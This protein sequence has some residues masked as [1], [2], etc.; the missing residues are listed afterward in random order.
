MFIV[1]GQKLGA[2]LKSFRPLVSYSVNIVGSIC[3]VGLFAVF[4]DLMLK[5]LY[6]FLFGLLVTLWFFYSSKKQLI[7]QSIIV[8]FT[9][10]LVSQLDPTS[11]WSPYYKIDISPMV[12]KSSHKLFGF[13]IEVNNLYHQKAFDLSDKTI[14][15]LPELKIYKD[16]YEFPYNFIQPAKVLILGAG[17]GND[18][19]AA[20]R[21]GVKE[22]YAVEIDPFIA[23]LGKEWQSLSPYKDQK[24]S[25]FID[26]ARSFINKRND[27]FDLIVFGYLDAHKVFSQFSSVRIDNFIY[28]KE[29]FEA[30]KNHLSPN[31][32]VAVTYLAFS[33]WA[34]NKLYASIEEVF[35]ENLRVFKVSVDSK[36]DTV[37]FLAGPA[38]NNIKNAD[39]SNFKTYNAF[40]KKLP[41][42]S[43]NWPYLY[44]FKRSIPSHYGIILSLVIFISLLGVFY[45]KPVSMSKFN[46][47]F[48]FLGAGFML[49]ETVSVTR[50]ALL[51]GSTWVVNSVV[52]LS[53]L[54]MILL[55]N[56]YTEVKKKVNIHLLYV[57]LIGSIFL[58]WMIKPNSY[59]IFTREIR[60]VLVSFVLSLPLFFAGIIFAVSFKKS[61]EVPEAFAYNLLGAILGGLCEYISMI[62]GFSFLLIVAA[63]MYCLSYLIKAPL[64]P[65]KPNLPREGRS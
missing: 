5:P 57:L 40:H 1:L 17:S 62:T 7:F 32:M 51:F 11:K 28:T 55:S 15:R 48:F 49:L 59:L 29:S 24:V 46:M 27:K 19:L 8:V 3:G 61:K 41:Y 47:H 60:T 50:F 20:L 36:D 64:L 58:N 18:Y 6:W 63:G 65:T 45:V 39:L 44:L 42:I 52:I 43:D 33:E 26:D 31:G 34:A 12:D 54:V 23:Y 10:L 35:G 14:A 53:I 22:V 2:C 30:V 38:V 25:L 37:I 56:L 16:V 13:G 4:S 9:L 21:K